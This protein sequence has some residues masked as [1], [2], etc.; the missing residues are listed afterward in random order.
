MHAYSRSPPTRTECA[1][2][3]APVVFSLYYSIDFPC[4]FVCVSTACLGMFYMIV[5]KC[6]VHGVLS[7]I[8][9]PTRLGT[10]TEYSSTASTHVRTRVHVYYTFQY[11]IRTG[12]VSCTYTCTRNV[13][14]GVLVLSTYSSTIWYVR[15]YEYTCE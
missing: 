5:T 13:Y 7:H 4:V 15:T 2:E 11:S 9:A 1:A 10:S 12:T 3:N 8:N 6:A 14:S